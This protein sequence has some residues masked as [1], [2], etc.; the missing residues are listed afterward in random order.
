MPNG[1]YECRRCHRY[2]P[3]RYYCIECREIV[4]KQLAAV[5]RIRRGS[6]TERGYDAEHKRLRAQ[7]AELVEMGG[8][9]CARCAGPI[10]AGSKWDLGH[11]DLDRSRYTGPEHVRCNRATTTHRKARN[12]R[13]A[14]AWPW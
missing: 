8:V 11:D 1:L 6:S 9:R 5:E 14:P 7:W 3:R 4:D 13:R 12:T 2:S 10:P